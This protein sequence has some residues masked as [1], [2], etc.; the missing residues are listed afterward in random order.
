MVLAISTTLE[1]RRKCHLNNFMFK[2]SNNIETMD[3]MANSIQTRSMSAKIFI[4]NKP[5]IESY[6]RSIKYSGSS[7]WSSLPL[8]VKTERIFDIF[9]YCQKKEM[10]S[11]IQ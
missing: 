7:M 5:N 11:F 4:I 2:R 10:L 1:K 8:E 9:K 6:K 3:N